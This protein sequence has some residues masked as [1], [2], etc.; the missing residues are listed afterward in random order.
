MRYDLTTTIADD[1]L[2]C[3]PFHDNIKCITANEY[4]NIYV[5]NDYNYT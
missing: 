3:S 1:W 5:G 2:N 4:K